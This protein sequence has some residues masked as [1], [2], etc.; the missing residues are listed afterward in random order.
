MIIKDLCIAKEYTAKDGTAKKQYTKIGVYMQ[1]DD[2]KAAIKL[3]TWFNPAGAVN[4]KGECW[5]GVFD[6]KINSPAPAKTNN[7]PQSD[8]PF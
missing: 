6:P 7:V 1:K 8:V 3:E 2:G 4:D 5:V